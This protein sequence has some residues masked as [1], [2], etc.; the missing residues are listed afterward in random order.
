MIRCSSVRKAPLIDSLLPAH[1]SPV[2][3]STFY[4]LTPPTARFCPNRDFCVAGAPDFKP[5]SS[6]GRG[7]ADVGAESESRVEE[8]GGIYGLPISGRETAFSAAEPTNTPNRRKFPASLRSAGAL[9]EPKRK[10][11]TC[12]HTV[13]ELD[14]DRI[15]G[16]TV[17]AF[18]QARY[19]QKYIAK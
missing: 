14:S 4:T 5:T 13:T 16:K 9:A 8:L 12:E 15:Q 10:S 19:S 6:T 7:D 3:P 2:T 18:L 11:R 17:G 1:R